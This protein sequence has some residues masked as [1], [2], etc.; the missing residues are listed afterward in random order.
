MGFKGKKP[1]SIE[2]CLNCEFEDAVYTAALAKERAA[3]AAARSI[4]LVGC[5]QRAA[6][7]A[8]PLAY[9]EPAPLVH[10]ASGHAHVGS[11]RRTCYSPAP[12][13]RTWRMPTARPERRCWAPCSAALT[14]TY[15]VARSC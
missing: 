6:G 14:A 3:A 4:D 5:M 9:R 13:A 11:G 12:T 1:K 8:H 7:S 10:D 2:K 15:S